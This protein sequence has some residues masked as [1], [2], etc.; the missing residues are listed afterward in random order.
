MIALQSSGHPNARRGL[1][2]VCPGIFYSWACMVRNSLASFLKAY[3]FQ[4]EHSAWSSVLA[5]TLA[6]SCSLVSDFDP[7]AVRPENDPVN[8][9]GDQAEFLG[10][11]NAAVLSNSRLYVVYT[12][13]EVE[14]TESG[15]IRLVMLDAQTGR[16]INPCSSSEPESRLSSL[17]AFAYAGTAVA[18]ARQV[19]G[20]EAKILAGWSEQVGTQPPRVKLRFL[21][22]AGCPLG[23]TFE[24]AIDLS[25]PI[26]QI[27]LAWSEPRQAVRAVFHSTR[28]VY[29]AWIYDGTGSSEHISTHALVVDVG[30]AFDETGRGLMGW[31]AL[32]DSGAL[33][34]GRTTTWTQLIDSDGKPRAAAPARGEAGSFPVD[35]P[36]GH[37]APN[38]RAISLAVA[39]S[40]SQYVIAID[41]AEENSG[42]SEIQVVQLS[43]E[44]GL[45][46]RTPIVLPRAADRQAF[47]SIAFLT[48]DLLL[49][50]WSGGGEGGT[51][52][53]LLD[54]QGKPV[55]NSVSCGQ[56]AFAL[57][58]D[59]AVP[60]RGVPA[61]VRHDDAI[62][63]VHT[64]LPPFDS[65]EVG[66]LAWRTNLSAL[67][68]AL[69]PH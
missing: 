17:D 23:G 26:E 48:S 27:A 35:F 34:E 47:P 25:E 10:N 46:E 32:D 55:F 43:A 37:F 45:H 13:Q 69:L 2:D 20:R 12:A 54:S 21:D 19:A 68:P 56:S 67:W 7:C 57:S 65:R 16:R 62:W 18:V 59:R 52:A 49:V 60:L 50:A 51:R 22:E 6:A 53:M 14:P 5:T 8:A 24:T 3:P 30:I 11:S 4:R 44:T 29:A 33:E 63:I 58:P 40:R 64:A 31:T 66:I 15:V 28:N 36:R 39:A 61:I 42:S 38:E 41:G 1:V 9:R